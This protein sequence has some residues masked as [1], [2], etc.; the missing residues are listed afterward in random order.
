MDR[1]LEVFA[2]AAA[3]TAVK[4]F[5]KP[6]KASWSAKVVHSQS[7]SK[8]E[9]EKAGDKITPLDERPA[10]AEA[11]AAFVVVASLGRH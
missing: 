7:K 4:L 5:A 2:A 11:A 8:S 6:C 1:S 9:R 10:A 3:A